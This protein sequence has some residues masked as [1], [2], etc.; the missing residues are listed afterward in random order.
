MK[1]CKFFDLD[2][3]HYKRKKSAL[4]I[5]VHLCE[6]ALN[7]MSTLILSLHRYVTL[8]KCTLN[9]LYLSLASSLLLVHWSLLFPSITFDKV[10][11]FD[12]IVQM[13]LP[14]ELFSIIILIF[15]F[16]LPLP[17]MC[18]LIYAHLCV[19]TCSHSK[20]ERDYWTKNRDTQWKKL[21]FL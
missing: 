4:N 21:S 20:C 15:A 14:F 18:L 6:R 3:D 7:W 11:T 10:Q 5:M 16:S 9:C 13:V 12:L 19:N 17:K 8:A 2:F 1:Q